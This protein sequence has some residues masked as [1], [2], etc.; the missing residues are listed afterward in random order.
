M[1][2]TFNDENITPYTTETSVHADVFNA[3][4]E[5]L[6][7]NT[8]YNKE[9]HEALEKEMLEKFNALD[10]FTKKEVIA[11]MEK[12]LKGDK[13]DQGIG[14]EYQ[15]NQTSLG[16]KTTEE[17]EF[18]FVNLK[19][20]KGQD[21]TVAFDELTEEQRLSLKGDAFT[22]EDFTEEQLELLKGVPG[23]DGKDGLTTKIELNGEVYTQENGLIKLPDY[24][25][26]LPASDVYD[27][28]KQSQKPSYS[29]SEILNMP[30]SLP[31]NGGN[32]DTVDGL[33]A[34]Q[35]GTLAADGGSH[36]A[37][38]YLY[39]KHNVYGDGRFALL[40]EQGIE[41][42]VD[43]AS[44]LQGYLPR[45]AYQD[46][47]Y[48][49]LTGCLPLE[50]GQWI[51]FHKQGSTADFDGR[52]YFDPANG[53]MCWQD[54]IN[55]SAYNMNIS[56]EIV[57]LKQS[58]ANGKQAVV[59]AI[60]NKLGYASGLTTA[61]SGAD[62]AWWIS[63]KIEKRIDFKTCNVFNA[64]NV[65]APY[66]ILDYLNN[67]TIDSSFGIIQ[68]ISCGASITFKITCISGSVDYINNAK[69]TVASRGTLNPSDS[70]LVFVSLYYSLLL[71]LSEGA[72][73]KITEMSNTSGDS[74]YGT[75]TGL[76]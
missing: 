39:A 3:T 35:M 66:G 19:G 72:S 5:K 53:G 8:K 62:Y 22:Y 56:W 71:H 36:G 7:E 38:H 29:A 52:L 21:G 51:D 47:A 13:G 76:K 74:A 33:H 40:T 43:C 16:I 31:A 28:A 41:T 61:H 14:L 1:S 30:T 25:T 46:A 59:D 32:S 60:N 26:T 63:N 9:R 65:G 49:P 11:L 73:Y 44:S 24:P 75:F 20:D 34:W 12:G 48:V 58:V 15:W 64:I 42:R 54:T 23:E 69:A 4:T 57:N 17:K 70:V 50:I 27:W 18:T 45:T 68:N 10:F 37:S 67:K 6:L 55:P 2:Y